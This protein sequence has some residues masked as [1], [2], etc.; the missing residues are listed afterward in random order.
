MSV[1]GNMRA[2]ATRSWAFV[3]KLPRVYS[4]GGALVIVVLLVLGVHALTRQEP[5]PSA[6]DQTPH[7]RVASVADLASGAGPLAIVGKVTSLNQA[8]IL[9]QTSGELVSLNV[10]IGD[11]VAA[12]QTIGSFENASEKAAVQQAQ[13][14][15]DAA[16]A[17]QSANSG[18]S[19]AISAQ[20]AYTSAYSTLDT[21]MQDIDSF[22]GAPTPVGP[23]LLIHSATND[24]TTLER[25]RRSVGT[26]IE[27]WRTE[28]ANATSTD[29]GAL[30]DDA[31]ATTQDASS[32]L[33]D[34]AQSATAY[35]SGATSAQLANL[36]TARSAV[37]GLLS[38]LSAARNAYRSTSPGASASVEQAL[39][40]LNG[41]KA[42]LAKTV[43]RSP[44]SGTIVSLPVTQGDFV[45]S[46]SP[47]ATVSNP[48]A[49]EIDAYVSA[50]DAKTLAAGGSATIENAVTGTIVSVAPALDPATGKILV[51]IALTG[52]A[53]ALTDG[54]TVTVSLARATSSPSTAAS[55]AVTIPL[56][57]AKITP[58]GPIV[59]TVSSSTLV[60]QPITIGTVLGDRVQ[61]TGGLASSTEIVTD[62]RG[63]AEGE[64][65]I[66]DAP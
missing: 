56:T 60:A 30:L 46:F 10:A 27:S 59:F 3:R 15:Y 40:A 36:A 37:A 53:S 25:E 29:P 61:V 49:L 62:A 9:A 22:F 32:F 20:N 52:D 4:I 64:A 58:Q 14:A 6:P 33:T 47:V 42:N 41:A 54:D 34:L 66:V 45:S 28:L 55:E 5:A 26:E 17:A 13:G 43:V 12:G 38:T 63:L 57:A 23:E 50:D 21:A 11:S 39:G 51:K 48:H 24:P 35:N 7:V 1:A 31:Y 8:S 19:T 18:A 16:V 2:A 44:I 65:V